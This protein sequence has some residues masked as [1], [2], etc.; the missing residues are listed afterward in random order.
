MVWPV[1][2]LARLRAFLARRCA[3]NELRGGHEALADREFLARHG[4]WRGPYDEA[5]LFFF[6][7]VYAKHQPKDLS[8]V[9]KLTGEMTEVNEMLQGMDRFKDIFICT[10]NLLERL[11]PAALH[12]IQRDQA[13]VKPVC[14]GNAARRVFGA[15]GGPVPHQARG[16]GGPKHGIFGLICIV[17]YMAA[18]VCVNQLRSSCVIDTGGDLMLD[19]VTMT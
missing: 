18:N 16:A 14:K 15:V 3:S 13:F 19:H 10:T 17:G 9:L 8:A 6:L 2:V 7:H 12:R 1:S 11:N 4:L 5:T